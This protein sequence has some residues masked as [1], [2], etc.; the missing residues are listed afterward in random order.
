MQTCPQLKY[1]PADL[2]IKF[3][4]V[5]LHQNQPAEPAMWSTLAPPFMTVPP[6]HGYSLLPPRHADS[7]Y[8]RYAR[9]GKTGEP[10]GGRMSVPS[11][12]QLMNE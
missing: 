1:R 8:T 6:S 7:I 10:S 9:F 5:H 3:R 12:V 2:R 4:V 11:K